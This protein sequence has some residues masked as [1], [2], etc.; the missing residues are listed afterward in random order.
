MLQYGMTCRIF[1]IVLFCMVKL[2]VICMDYINYGYHQ[3]EIIQ[4]TLGRTL[5]RWN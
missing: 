3:M 5:I 1:G 4:L 2:E